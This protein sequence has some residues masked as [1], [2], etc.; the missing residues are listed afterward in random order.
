MTETEIQ[1]LQQRYYKT[2]TYYNISKKS[3]PISWYNLDVK[4]IKTYWTYCRTHIVGLA[5]C[6]WLIVIG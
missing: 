4:M 5:D 1:I 6:D 3:S 2:Y